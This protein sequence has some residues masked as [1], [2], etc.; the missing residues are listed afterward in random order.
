MQAPRQISTDER[1]GKAFGR[2]AV[3]I[4]LGLASNALPDFPKG[5]CYRRFGPMPVFVSG[6]NFTMEIK[7]GLYPNL[8]HRIT[9]G[10][11]GK[12]FGD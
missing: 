9:S 5:S 1:R 12:A 3:D 8:L 2:S 10:N 4:I 7:I 6:K 11:T